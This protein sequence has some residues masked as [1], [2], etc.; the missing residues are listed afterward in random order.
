MIR[1]AAVVPQLSELAVGGGDDQVGVAVAIEIG[2]DNGSRVFQGELGC[3]DCGGLIGGANTA[4][5]IVRAT[6]GVL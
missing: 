2:R 5:R 4:N 1:V 3:A 6:S